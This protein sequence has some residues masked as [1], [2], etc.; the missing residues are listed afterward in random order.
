MT[1]DRS[2]IPPGG[3]C[4]QVV[5]LEPGETLSDDWDRFGLDLREF[6]YGERAKQVLCPY[7]TKTH[8][9]TVRCEWL[10]LEVHDDNADF[11]TSRAL[12]RAHFGE[13]EVYRRVKY[14]LLLSDE[15]KICD[16]NQALE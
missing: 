14:S 2:L 5:D 12:S 8:H 3:L 4:Y 16:I 1:H 15:I 9:G 13:V 6:K 7:W 10:D 11:E